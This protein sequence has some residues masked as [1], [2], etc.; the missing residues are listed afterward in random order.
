MSGEFRELKSSAKNQETD[1]RVERKGLSVFMGQVLSVGMNGPL[2]ATF[3]KI[4]KVA[5]KP[6][7]RIINLE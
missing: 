3:S 6:E 2:R 1:G 7:N 5:L 4:T